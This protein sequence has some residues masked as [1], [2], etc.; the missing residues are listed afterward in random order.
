[1]FINIGK[2]GIG[3]CIQDEGMPVH[4]PLS[5]KGNLYVQFK[6]RR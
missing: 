2:L 1:M 3:K 4:Q 5:E 6:V